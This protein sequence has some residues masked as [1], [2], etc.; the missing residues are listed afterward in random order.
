MTPDSIKKFRGVYR[1]YSL[2][3]PDYPAGNRW[4]PALM[5]GISIFSPGNLLNE[6]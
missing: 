3:L 2:F 5:T 4:E 6:P 1:F